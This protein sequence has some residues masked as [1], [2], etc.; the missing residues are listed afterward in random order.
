VDATSGARWFTLYQG[1]KVILD[2]IT[3]LGPV[4]VNRSGTDFL[5]LVEGTNRAQLIRKASLEPWSHLNGTLTNSR[6]QFLG[7]D[8][9]HVEIGP[10]PETD[11]RTPQ[12]TQSTAEV[13]LNGQVIYTA[14][15]QDRPVGSGFIGFWT[16]GDH[17][18]LET[19]DQV[20][21]D[22]Q[23]VN[24]LNGYEKSYEFHLL[25]GRPL[26]FFEQSGGL[27]V[28]FDSG[29]APLPFPA[30]PHYGCCSAAANNPVQIGDLLILYG[31]QGESWFYMEMANNL[32][33]N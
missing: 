29:T 15:Y 27:S 18:A 22:G 9:M 14:H 26:F 4:S 16:Y 30:I 11:A 31:M 5:L 32:T 8:L 12:P 7:N 2:P 1:E 25:G 17:W 24:R 28:S 6:P 19:L 10:P 23:D 20:V 21:I 13:F 3:G 33:S